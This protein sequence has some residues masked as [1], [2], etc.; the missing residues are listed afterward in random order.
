MKL[1]AA[2]L[3]AEFPNGMVLIPDDNNSPSIGGRI[4]D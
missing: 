1:V 3:E 2:T 4:F